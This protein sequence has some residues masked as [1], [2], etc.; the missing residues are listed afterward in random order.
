MR[1]RERRKTP[2]NNVKSRSTLFSHRLIF[3]MVIRLRT[4]SYCICLYKNSKLDP[5]RKGERKR[6]QKRFQ[7]GAPPS[8]CSLTER[9]PSMVKKT[10]GHRSTTLK[11]RWLPGTL[12][13]LGQPFAILGHPSDMRDVVFFK[14]IC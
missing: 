6:E 4:R 9:H 5:V 10:L 3:Y 8:K 13:I 1:I 7:D 11:N 2:S 14:K 12:S